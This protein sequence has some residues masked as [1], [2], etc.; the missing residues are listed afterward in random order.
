MLSIR[1]LPTH[2]EI[3]G[4]GLALLYLHGAAEWAGYSDLL[5]GRLEQEYRVVQP[6]R[7]GHGRTPDVSGSLHYEEMA[8]DTIALIE[9]MKLGP[10]HVVGYSDGAIIALRVSCI[11]P[12]LVSKVVAIGPN[13]SVSGLTDDALKWLADVTPDTWSE[14]AA[15]MH[16]SLSPDGPGH[17]PVFAQKVIDMLRREPEIPLAELAAIEAPMLI[18]GA[19]RDMIRQEHLV[20]IFRAIP[21][22]QLCIIPGASHELTVEVPALLAQVITRFLDEPSLSD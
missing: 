9:E 7:R 16:R 22:A 21:S 12:D 17:W 15:T 4:S 19:D 5:V 13:V 1:G 20:E 18:V 6:E 2:V 3:G 14:E 10:V 8:R 11:R